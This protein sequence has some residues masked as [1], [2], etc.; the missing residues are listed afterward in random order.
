[1]RWMTRP[2]AALFAASMA[3]VALAACGGGSQSESPSTSVSQ[4]PTGKSGATGGKS[5]A[6]KAGG[7]KSQQSKGSSG[8]SSSSGGGGVTTPLKVSGGGSG[9]YRVRGSD[10]SIQN[11]GEEGSASELRQAAEAVHGFYVARAEE[12]WRQACLRL[13]GLMAGQLDILASK[14]PQLRGKGCPEVLKGLT[15]PLP[16]AVERETTLVDAGSLRR[17]GERGF[18][19]Y[20]GAEGKAYA[21]PV[22]LESE[23]WLVAALAGTPLE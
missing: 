13:A 21:I 17:E 1:M 9:Q 16:P 8:G 12:K 7:G 11:F 15:Q 20:R 4:A 19:I 23:G 6:T 5:H 10:N 22:H 2:V 18:L 14:S 3:A